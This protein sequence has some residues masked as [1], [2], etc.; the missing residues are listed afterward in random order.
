MAE[1]QTSVFIAEILN[2]LLVASNIRPGEE[3][4]FRGGPNWSSSTGYAAIEMIE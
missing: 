1:H 4:R 3:W 2:T